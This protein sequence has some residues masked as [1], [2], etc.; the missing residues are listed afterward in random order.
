MNFFSLTS[1]PFKCI[2]ESAPKE[3]TIF[4]GSKSNEGVTTVPVVP[5]EEVV[6]S[7][8]V[9]L[10]SVVDDEDSVVLLHYYVFYR[11]SLSLNY[12][13]QKMI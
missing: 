7:L 11:Q 3:R 5:V 12:L 13:K 4:S 8:D 6:L 1:D 10:F 9:V 2:S